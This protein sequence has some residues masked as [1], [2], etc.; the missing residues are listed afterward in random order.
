MYVGLLYIREQKPLPD[1]RSPCSQQHWKRRVH[2]YEY[3]GAERVFSLQQ[4]NNEG[5]DQE[6]N[7]SRRKT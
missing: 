3:A 4:A 2:I 5:M 6:R 7:H 1:G